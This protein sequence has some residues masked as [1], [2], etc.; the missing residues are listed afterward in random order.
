MAVQTFRG[1]VIG[2]G[3]F[4]WLPKR[5]KWLSLG[6]LKGPW[7]ALYPAGTVPQYRLHYKIKRRVRLRLILALLKLL[8]TLIKLKKRLK[9]FGRLYL[10]LLKI[11][12][13]RVGLWLVFLGL[14]ILRPK[15]K[16]RGGGK[17][18]KKGRGE[19]KK[20][21]GGKEGKSGEG[22]KGGKKNKGE[23]KE[24]GKRGGGE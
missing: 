14:H 5:F 1:E 7:V 18:R 13:F 10:F 8:L 3:V 21:G 17:R 4:R 9:P 2:S 6:E 22:F 24:K 12:K 23:D 11:F 19:K 15:K 16:R 20:R